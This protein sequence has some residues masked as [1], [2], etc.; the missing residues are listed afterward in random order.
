M[1]S[2]KTSM[3]VSVLL[4]SVCALCH[5]VSYRFVESQNNP[6]TDPVMLWLN[7]GPGC[8]AMEGMLS[9]NGPFHVSRGAR[10]SFP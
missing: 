3:Q 10:G 2:I 5:D 1:N 8:S 9:E 4:T 6:S 7:G